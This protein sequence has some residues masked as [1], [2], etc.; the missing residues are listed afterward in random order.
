MENQKI[1]SFA[2]FRLPN[3][4]QIHQIK[5]NC[6]LRLEPIST[7]KKKAFLISTFNQSSSAYYINYVDLEIYNPEDV[8]QFSFGYDSYTNLGEKH[9]IKIVDKAIEEMRLGHFQKVVL[10]NTQTRPS[11]KFDPNKFFRKIEKAYPK[12]FVYWYSSPQTG[13][14]FGA[15]PEPLL[16]KLGSN[17]NTVAL[18]GTKLASEEKE[19]TEKEITEQKLV[20]D[21]VIQQLNKHQLPFKK[22]GPFNYA[23]GKLL[24]LKTEFN[25]ESENKLQD[26]FAFLGDLNPTP[27]VAG[28]PIKD[29]VEFILKEENFDRSCYT[30]FIGLMNET[31]LQLFVN[32]RCLQWQK[33]TITLFAGAGITKES[34]AFSEWQ[35]TQNK[36]NA[37]AGFL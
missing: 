3:D 25:F 37:L 20:E 34:N 4:N 15:T 5:G 16:T 1:D 21:F 24:H 2:V 14:W 32:L 8:C 22:N 29:S 17:Y 18:A 23:S 13:T 27:A 31:N 26:A 36:M 12:A 35:E 30:G 10:A 6:S 19:W 11:K 7:I 33:E 9:Y 28:F